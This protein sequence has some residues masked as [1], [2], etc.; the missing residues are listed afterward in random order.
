MVILTG[1]IVKPKR[2]YNEGYE[3]QFGNA[4]KAIKSRKIP[5]AWTGGAKIPGYTYGQ[6]KEID[7]DFGGKLSW[8]GYIWDLEHTRNPYT[9]EDLGWFTT[10]I[11]IM[12]P[13]GNDEIM[14]IFTLDSTDMSCL[15]PSL[16]G[17]PCVPIAAVEWLELQ[18]KVES[19]DFK[20]RDFIFIHR[21]L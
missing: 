4:M 21:P 17:T 9:Q 8:T 15:D 3:A 20:L 10:R 7:N 19:H 16:A 1:D 18:Q 5:Y 2:S 6:L 14:S 11:P 13:R 12:S